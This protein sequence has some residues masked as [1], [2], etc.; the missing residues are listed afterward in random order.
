MKVNFQKILSVLLCVA[1]SFSLLC[2][3]VSAFTFDGENRSIKDIYSDWL[4]STNDFLN[5]RSTFEQW[6]NSNIRFQTDLIGSNLFP[7]TETELDRYM[8]EFEDKL[9]TAVEGSENCVDD[10]VLKIIDKTIET[11][12]VFD[13]REQFEQWYQDKYGKEYGKHENAFG[14]FE[15]TGYNYYIYSHYYSHEY[16]WFLTYSGKPIKITETSSGVQYFSGSELGTFTYRKYTRYQTADGWTEWTTSGEYTG[17]TATK[18]YLN[19]EGSETVDITNLPLQIGDDIKGGEPVTD[20][21]S[22]LGGEL[23]APTIT[24]PELKDLLTDLDND[25]QNSEP[26]DDSP[27]KKIELKIT[28]LINKM[29]NDFSKVID[30]LNKILAKLT[31]FFNKFVDTFG[32]FF[33]KLGEFF[34]SIF[35]PSDDCFSNFM[36]DIQAEFDDAFSFAGDIRLLCDTAVNAYKNG[37]TSAPDISVDVDGVGSHNLDLSFFDSNMPLIRSILCAFIYCTFAFNLYRRIPCYISGG[38]ER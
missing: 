22:E 3:N 4:N 28:Q 14:N 19:Y 7:G 16:K 38:G 15:T 35:V 20:W 17:T 25:L 36:L 32:N 24:L 11:I 18:F 34:Q 27:S 10:S 8:D 5:G 6:R 9:H 33:E 37:S 30:V 21:D 23:V 12:G 26:S 13:F 31:E 2:I 1:L 29:H